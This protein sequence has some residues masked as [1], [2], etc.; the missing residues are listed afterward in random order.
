MPDIQPEENRTAGAPR[1]VI[2]WLFRVLQGVIIGA[3]AILPGISGGVL[4]VVF[5]IYQPMMALLAHP[6]RTFKK[7]VR[8]LLPVLIGW[9]LGFFLIAKVLDALFSSDSSSNPATWLF[10]GL[11]IGTLP[12]LY[13]EAG[14]QGRTYKSRIAFVVSMV[15]I[16]TLLV[17]LQYGTR[18]SID[19]N[20]WWYIV[21]GALWGTSLVVP[22]LS[23]SSLLLFL[24][25]YQ[26]MTAGISNFSLE[27]IIPMAV[28]IMLVIF[29]SARAINYMFDKHYSSSFH[30]VLGFVIA[31]TI[32]IILPASGNTGAGGEIIGIN[33]TTDTVTILIWVAC[34]AVGF[35]V[36]WFMD[37]I[38]KKVQSRAQTDQA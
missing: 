13:R 10:F 28:G 37:R 32:A 3:G 38:G 23:S 22:G 35:A 11:I 33:Y 29:L 30:A 20:I 14:K 2:Q 25:L 8:L 5:G 34:F 16:L 21:C 6:F 26:S 31:S 9:A 12:Q 24:G 17:F 1:T 19:A 36:A 27:V 18:I 15:L 4:C 7:Y